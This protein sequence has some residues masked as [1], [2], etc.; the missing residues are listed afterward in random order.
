MPFDAPEAVPLR[1]WKSALV[2]ALL[3]GASALSAPAPAQAPAKKDSLSLKDVLGKAQTESETK[4][5]EDL[6]DKLKGGARK[7]SP[8]AAAAPPAPQAPPVVAAPPAPPSTATAPE[9]TDRQAA[10]EARPPVSSGDG[11]PVPPA[12]TTTPPA[13]APP[14][15]KVATPVPPKETVPAPPAARP[16]PDV[17]VESAEK[18]QR[19]SVDLEVLFAYKSDEITSEAAAMLRPLGRALSDARLASDAFLIAGHTDAKGGAT[20]NLDLSQR[21]AEAVRRF[22]IANFGIDAQKLVAK[23]YG[24]QRLKNPA[25]PLAAE[26][27][28]VQI[29]NLTKDK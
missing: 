6:V 5:V 25:Q 7:T 28:R 27:R 1:N 23:G 19:P 2:A 22:L 12:K 13:A 24:L 3:L 15:E 11:T 10:K 26:N 29:V 20:Y 17:A 16:S 21:R 18:Q 4:A 14:G 8:P 9:S